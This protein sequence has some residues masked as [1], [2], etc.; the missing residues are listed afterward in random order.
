[1]ADY[2][3]FQRENETRIEGR[4]RCVITAVEEGKSKTSG[5]DMIIVSLRPSGCKFEIKD[6]IVKND[7][8][9]RRMTAFFDAFPEITFGDFNFLSWVGC[10]GA[11]NLAEDDRGFLKV[12]GYVDPVKARNLPPFEGN[13]PPR[14]QITSLAEEE[15]D[16]DLP[17]EI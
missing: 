9:N 11:V 14:Q 13:K 10:E 3:D 6:Y 2:S 17:F 7:S 12:K 8:F 16:G 1:M 15:D 4:Q 5:N